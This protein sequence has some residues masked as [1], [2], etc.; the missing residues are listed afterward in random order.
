MIALASSKGGSGK[1]TTALALASAF[2]ADGARVGIVDADRSGRLLRWSEHGGKASAD[3]RSA[4]EKTIRVTVEQ[5]QATC[6]VVL[7]DVEGTANVGLALAVG[8]ADIVLVP[9]NPSAPD[10]EDGLAT[11]NLIKDIEATSRRAIPH[12]FVWTRVPNIKSREILAL[13]A[14]VH[15]A[16]V[17]VIGF[18]SERTAYK[19]LF[20]YSTDLNRLPEADVP[21]VGKAKTEAQQLATLVVDFLEKS[22]SRKEQQHG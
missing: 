8:L 15:K 16:Q 18:L 12:G 5:L 19:S 11:I 10:V 4:T 7:V 2:C 9:A 3:V 6:D 14:E 20:S 13:H 17:E 22:S 1:S 21:G